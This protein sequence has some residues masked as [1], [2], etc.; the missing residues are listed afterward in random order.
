MEDWKSSH[1]QKVDGIYQE[2][3]QWEDCLVQWTQDGTCS[4]T[5][6][7]THQE[8]HVL[9]QSEPDNDCKTCF[10]ETEDVFPELGPLEDCMDD[11][12]K[13]WDGTSS[14]TAGAWHS[15]GHCIL[16]ESM[17]DIMQSLQE[18]KMILL[19]KICSVANEQDYKAE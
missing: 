17:P 6:G 19:L 14:P 7:S 1:F 8:H 12:L 3:G 18:R 10:Q 2:L 11:M 13:T 5:A 4:L 15:S 16:P 9:P